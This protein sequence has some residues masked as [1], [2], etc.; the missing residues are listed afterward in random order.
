MIYEVLLW[1]LVRADLMFGNS[2]NI[3]AYSAF[4]NL[5]TG[6]NHFK[7]SLGVISF[8]NSVR[9]LSYSGHGYINLIYRCHLRFSTHM[10]KCSTIKGMLRFVMLYYSGYKSKGNISRIYGE[11]IV[12]IA[13]INRRVWECKNNHI[14]T[15]FKV[16]YCDVGTIYAICRDINIT[17]HVAIDVFLLPYVWIFSL[18][19]LVRSHPKHV[20]FN[21]SV[22][23]SG[24]L[25]FI[26]K[27]M[28]CYVWQACNAIPS[29]V[30]PICTFYEYFHIK[31]NRMLF[32]H[33]YSLT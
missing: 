31:M 33:T 11:A 15:F 16:S 8:S 13:S 2:M 32:I 12:W 29:V 7:Y 14:C 28:L 4:C 27:K 5:S 18:F 20:P 23:R 21:L 9:K 30:D 10:I 1:T 26:W 24:H 19:F 17:S 25:K 3:I 22:S 6:S